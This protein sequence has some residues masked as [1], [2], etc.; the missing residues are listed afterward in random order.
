MAM[1]LEQCV[2]N[3]VLYL[4]DAVNASAETWDGRPVVIYHPKSEG[5]PI[6]ANNPDTFTSQNV[7][8][9]FNTKVLGGK[10]KAEAWLEVVKVENLAD[11]KKLIEM[12]EANK[13]IDV[14]TGMRIAGYEENGQFGGNEYTIVANQITPDHLAILLD[15]K[16]AC[17][18]EDG[19]GFAR[20]K[21]EK[22]HALNKELN[23]NKESL[24]KR[25]EK[26]SA[27]IKS[28]VLADNQR[29]AFEKMP[30]GDFDSFES[31]AK[32]NEDNAELIA[33]N[34]KDSDLAA[35]KI[36]DAAKLAENAKK[37]TIEGLQAEVTTLK[38]NAQKIEDGKKQVHI[39]A[40]LANKENALTQEQLIGMDCEVLAGIAKL[41]KKADYSVNVGSG[42]NKP[43]QELSDDEKQMQNA[44]NKPEKKEGE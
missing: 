32:Q 5:T 12:L 37:Q 15:E 33:Q 19:A 27:L 29:E 7:G 3:G 11:G 43:A 26:V 9:I 22:E 8:T 25:Q 36:K 42:D 40:I 28:G 6:S 14:S 1:M 41:N 39:D 20:N 34:K 13:N 17:S 4:K 35:E 44:G 21:D 31:L 16:G 38:E 18:W 30:D 23:H 24:M 2:M 10:L